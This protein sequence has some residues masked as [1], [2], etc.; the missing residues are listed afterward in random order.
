MSG[1]NSDEGGAEI[2][3]QWKN[4]V[5][6]LSNINFYDTLGSQLYLSFLLCSEFALGNSSSLLIDTHITKTPSIIV[7]N[8]QDGRHFASGTISSGY[9]DLEKTV[10]QL[11]GDKDTYVY[12]SDYVRLGA[13][14]NIAETILEKSDS[15]SVKLVFFDV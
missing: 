14:E 3:R 9:T 8:R 12:D 7:G 13:C 10:D 1:S 2:N 11:Y 15:L 5:N 4:L 6:K